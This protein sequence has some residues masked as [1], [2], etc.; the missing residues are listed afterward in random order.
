VQ[1]L[2][3]CMHAC[4]H[5]P[6][7]GGF[8]GWLG[9]CSGRLVD[10][11][12]CAQLHWG[13]AMSH[14]AGRFL[15]RGWVACV[16]GMLSAA[17]L[18]AACNDRTW[19]VRC[20]GFSQLQPTVAGL[21]G[22]VETETAGGAAGPGGLCA[23]ATCVWRISGSLKGCTPSPVVCTGCMRIVR[24]APTGCGSSTLLA[25]ASWCIPQ[26]SPPCFVSWRFGFGGGG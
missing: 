16:A 24:T 11:R 10:W 23:A 1:A 18:G 19:R 5:G 2:P 22:A 3:P 9:A 26:G 20:A 14:A 17:L 25:S 6:C 7:M 4:M 12:H 13:S 15:V 21:F 8:K